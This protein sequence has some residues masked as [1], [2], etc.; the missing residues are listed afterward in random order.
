MRGTKSISDSL[1]EQRRKAEERDAARR[2]AELGLPYLDLIST[3]VP[4]E[5]A[6]LELVPEAEA[7]NAKIAPLEVTRKT[8]IVAV[9]D[10]RLQATRAALEK[11]GANHTLDVRIASLTGLGHAW[12]HYQYVL[13]NSIAITGKVD[14]DPKRLAEILESVKTLADLGREIK[15]FKSPLTSQLLDIVLGSALALHASDIH[16]EP[17]AGNAVLRLRIDGMLHDAYRDFTPHVHH[18]IVTRIK[19]LSNLKLNISD[20]PQDGRFTFGV[21]DRSIEVRTSLIPSEYGES[22][23]MR[24]LDPQAISVNLEDLGWRGDDLKIVQGELAKPNGLI[25]N[26]GPTGSGKTTTLYAFLKRTSTSELKVITVE[27]P[28]EYHLPGISQTQIDPESGYTFASGL[29]S[30]LRQDPDII[31]VGEIRDAETAEIAMN[32]ALTGHLVFS[33]L[34]TNDAVGAVPRLIELG[35]KPQTIGPALSLVIAQRLVRKLCEHC[36]KPHALTAH[37]TEAVRTFIDGLPARVDR[38]PYA[39]PTVFEPVGCD[40][41]GGIGYRGR[42]SVF[43]LFTVTDEIEE[44]IYRNPTET[45]MKSLAK[46]QGM[47]TMQE[48]GM[49][50][51]L[52][53]ITDV[54]EIVR[55]TGPISW[56]TLE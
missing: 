51:V 7:R 42:T 10:P 20:Q 14:L 1:E 35:S 27:D 4:T 43:E 24:I 12:D 28:I 44:A 34:H 38:T 19:L 39:S 40:K 36:K 49:L 41:C 5:I 56:W 47:V 13:D 15:E 33:T 22:V 32:A 18:S 29:R 30:I 45:E 25:L 55:F 8:V 50:K 6:A 31:L 17:T 2:A 23:V 16:L 11:L 37:E 54:G 52:A 46:Q 3:R 48:D 26:T 53:G 9:F 21:N